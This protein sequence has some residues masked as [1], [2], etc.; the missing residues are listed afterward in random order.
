MSKR[1]RTGNA[2]DGE[3]VNRAGQLD[4][5]DGRQRF[6]L[7]AQQLGT[8][9]GRRFVYEEIQRARVFD[10][11]RGTSEQMWLFLG[12]REVGLRLL[13]EVIEEHPAAFLLMEHEAIT[14]TQVSDEGQ[15]AIAPDA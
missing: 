10:V 12:Q 11:M 1:A 2:A 8:A 4:A 3:Q 5:S 9:A 6:A 7:L 15:Q 14:R 13:N